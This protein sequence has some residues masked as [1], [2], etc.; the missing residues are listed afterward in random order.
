[1]DRRYWNLLVLNAAGGKSVNPVQFQKALFLLQDKFPEAFSGKYHFR[2]YNFGPFD[3]AVY[4]DAEGLERRGFVQINQS[5]SG[6]KTYVVTPAGAA[7]AQR[8]K[9]QANPVALE[10]MRRVVEW[11]QGLSF[12]DLVKSIYDA[13]PDMRANSIF[14]D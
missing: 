6:L 2:P 5:P 9:S 8:L 11:A 1:M 4:D 14:K 10:Y 13:Y 12:Q 3:S 7:E